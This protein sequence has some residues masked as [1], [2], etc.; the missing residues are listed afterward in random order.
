MRVFKI[1]LFF[2]ILATTGCDNGIDY[3]VHGAGETETEYVIVEP[4]AEIWIDS[5]VQTASYDEVD[6]LW[7][8]DGSC[9]MLQHRGNLLAGIELMMNNLPTDV[10]WRLKMITTGDGRAVKQP[11]TFPLTRGDDI[12]DALAMYN[13]LPPD[14]MEKGFDAVKNYITLDSYASTWMRPSAALLT[15]FVSDEEDQSTQT[16]PDFIAWYQTL[17]PNVFSSFIGNVKTADSICTRPPGP[18]DVGLKYMDV[19]TYFLGTIID[20]CETDWSAGVQDATQKIDP[21]EELELT[22]EPY[23]STIVVFENGAPMDHAKWT[24]IEADNIIEFDPI[25]DEGVLVEI[26]YAVKYYTMP[27]P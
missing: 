16:A 27:S 2:L 3:V 24:Y 8:I 17:R 10:N 6:I 25:P 26:G 15:V 14:G 20:I 4:D 7:V 21:V 12:Y 11:Q 18:M 13:D 9:S 1:L 22:H 19:V 23:K 5:F